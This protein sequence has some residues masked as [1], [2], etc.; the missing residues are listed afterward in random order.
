[1]TASLASN[2]CMLLVSARTSHRTKLFP[3]CTKCHSLPEQTTFANHSYPVVVNTMTAA[4]LRAEHN[5]AGTCETSHGVKILQEK[6]RMNANPNTDSKGQREETRQPPDG[7][8]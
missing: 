4:Q 1:M 3:H 2:G 7:I 5:L 8:T 6:G